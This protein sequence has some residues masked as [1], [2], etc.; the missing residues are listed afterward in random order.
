MF[1]G[2]TRGGTWGSIWG[3][4]RIGCRG[5]IM[6]GIFGGTVSGN[7]ASTSSRDGT[8][9][10]TSIDFLNVYCNRQVQESSYCLL[11]L[12]LYQPT[13]SLCI[14]SCLIITM[15]VTNSP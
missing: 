2:S 8:W 7:L 1:C 11:K 4:I 5:C 12:P 14:K 10:G 9:G 3:V 13:D 15:T 6:G